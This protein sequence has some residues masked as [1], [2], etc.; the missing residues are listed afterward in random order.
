LLTLF[1]T[2][3]FISFILSTFAIFLEIPI[4][5]NLLIDLILTVLVLIYAGN[6]FGQGWPDNNWCYDFRKP[7][8]D[9]STCLQWR[10]VTRILMGIGGGLGFLIG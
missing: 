8:Y 2:Q 4:M 6:I 9:N 7:N 10:G 5:V 3:V 1:E